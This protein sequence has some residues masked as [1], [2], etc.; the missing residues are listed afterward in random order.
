MGEPDVMSRDNKSNGEVVDKKN[1]TGKKEYG[2]EDGWVVE[3]YLADEEMKEEYPANSEEDDDDSDNE[4]Q[5]TGEED[6]ATDGE[7]V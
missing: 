2:K 1:R 4:Y 5:S 6:E 7:S 3:E